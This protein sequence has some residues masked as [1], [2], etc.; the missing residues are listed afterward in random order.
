[1]MFFLSICVFG[2]RDISCHGTL[3]IKP[4]TENILSLLDDT[5]EI[6]IQKNN[7]LPAD[8]T[9]LFADLKYSCD[10]QV[11]ICEF[12]GI[13]A[14]MA[15]TQVMINGVKETLITPYW[16]LFWHFAKKYNKPLWHI[17]ENTPAITQELFTSHGRSFQ[18]LS[19]FKKF[20]DTTKDTIKLSN[21]IQEHAG[22]LILAD[23]TPVKT[24]QKFMQEYPGVLVV[25]KYTRRYTLK[26]HAYKFF[27]KDPELAGYMPRLQSYNKKYTPDLA[28]KICHDIP[29]EYFIIKPINSMQSKGV[30]MI[31]KA[32]LDSALQVI[33]RDTKTIAP[34]AH[35]SLSYWK[36]DKNTTFFVEEYASSKTIIINKKE[37]DPTMRLIFFMSHD[38]GIIKINVIAGYWKIPVKALS[39]D[40]TLTEKHITK[41]F[42]GDFFTGIVIAPDDMKNVK[43]TFKT[44]LSNIYVKMLRAK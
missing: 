15:D 25:N 39:D 37:Y 16:D 10:G 18:D 26:E 13:M 5:L 28:Q 22:I 36:H 32:G 42:S 3:H 23:N 24:R 9:Y 2:V 11:K 38:M 29:A 19:C 41:P 8:I 17:G 44:M 34:T 40:G 1:M 7:E 12:G 33:L 6:K 31:D 35:K 43:N 14:G 30:I 20:I 27:H 4:V 21:S